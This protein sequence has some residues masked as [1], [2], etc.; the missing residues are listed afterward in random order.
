MEVRGKA[1]LLAKH[2]AMK[3]WL[4]GSITFPLS[5]VVSSTFPPVYPTNLK[6]AG[7]IPDEVIFF[8]FT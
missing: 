1:A 2:Y 8:K 4:S 6:V 3:T 7:S 5:G